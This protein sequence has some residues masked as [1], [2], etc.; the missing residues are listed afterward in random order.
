MSWGGSE[1]LGE[2]PVSLTKV[3][4]KRQPRKRWTMKK[5]IRTHLDAD[6]DNCGW[7]LPIE[8]RQ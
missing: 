4:S 7:A 2:H 6:G 3:E 8:L 5:T 1:P